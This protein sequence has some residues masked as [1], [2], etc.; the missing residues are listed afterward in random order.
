LD[1]EGAVIEFAQNRGWTLRDGR[2]YFPV[3]AEAPTGPTE[4][5][6][7]QRPDKE[8]ALSSASVIENTIGYAREL[9]TI[10]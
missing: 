10:V 2:I 4:T 8:I 5:G 1:S 7:G 9:E 6:A 3:E